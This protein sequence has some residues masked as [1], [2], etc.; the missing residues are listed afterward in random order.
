M[1]ICLPCVAR[2]VRSLPAVGGK[3]VFCL[4]SFSSFRQLINKDNVIGLVVETRALRTNRI[5]SKGNVENTKLPETSVQ[6]VN[7]VANNFVFFRAFV[8]KKT[9]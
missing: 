9:A 5:W 4:A 8:V 2:C 7:S 1:K 3:G 6:S